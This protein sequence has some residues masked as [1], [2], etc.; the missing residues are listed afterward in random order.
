MG[1]ALQG[2]DD[3]HARRIPAGFPKYVSDLVEG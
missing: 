2:S 1:Q 3:E